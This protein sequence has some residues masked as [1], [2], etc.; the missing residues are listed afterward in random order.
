MMH[1]G[2]HQYLQLILHLVL[3]LLASHILANACV[4][5]EEEEEKE[6]EEHS[7]VAINTCMH[8]TCLSSTTQ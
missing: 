3:A 5:Q 7:G 8:A 4:S 1:A 2:N 6:E